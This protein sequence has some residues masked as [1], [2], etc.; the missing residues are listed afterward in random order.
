MT[1]ARGD[2]LPPP[3]TCACPSRDGYQCVR[4]RY[5]RFVADD[6]DMADY[7]DEEPCQCLCHDEWEDWCRGDED[8]ER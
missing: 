4:I 5:G 6:L 1:T 7:W 2:L 8:D 3:Q